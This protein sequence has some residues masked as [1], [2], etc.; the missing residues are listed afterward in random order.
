MTTIGIDL[1]TTNS[2]V[3]VWEEGGTRVIPNALGEL[4]TPSVVSVLDSGDVLVGQAAKDRLI[5]HPEVTISQ[6]KR[7]MGTREQVRLGSLRFSPEA[8]SSL[9]LRQLREDAEEYLGESVTEAIISVPAYFNDNQRNAT[10]VAGEMAGFKVERLINEPTAAALAYGVAAEGDDETFIVLDLGGGTFDVSILEKFDNL[11]E[12]HASAGDAFLGGEDFTQALVNDFL[13]THEIDKQALA[14]SELARLYKLAEQIKIKLSSSA[15][16]RPEV[17]FKLGDQT[18]HSV[19]SPD[20]FAEVAEPLIGRLLAPIERAIR[21]AKLEVDALERI[22]LVGGATRMPIMRNLVT[23][24]FGRFLEFHINPDHAVVMGA[25]VQAALKSRNQDFEDVV[26]TDVCPF[27]LGI[28][29]YNDVYSVIIERNTVIPVSRE[30]IYQTV[31]DKQK[32]IQVVIYQGEH[33][34]VTKNVALGDL[35]I[36]V[37]K[38]KAGEARITVRFTYDINGLLEVIVTALDS[39]KSKTVVIE[40]SPGR[41]TPREIKNALAQL[42]HIKLHPRDNAKYKALVARAERLYQERL[43]DDRDAIGGAIS[44]FEAVLESQDQQLVQRAAKQ[45]EHFLNELETD[46]WQ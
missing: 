31:Q 14:S 45:F 42:E 11:M 32:Q 46:F 23:R 1:G 36:P 44:T 29:L 38:K 33:R 13:Q 7:L 37:P 40:N 15:E 39:D 9:V 34:L 17:E 41:L 22:F 20:K 24:L 18:Y 6:F 30:E 25:A 2:L 5:S 21:D 16:S 35:A 12:V 26:L 10:R 43:G 8:L 4:L 27:S 28:G 19:Y 3:A